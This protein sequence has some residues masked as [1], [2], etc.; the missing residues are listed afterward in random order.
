MLNELEIKDLR[1]AL[2]HCT[3]LIYRYPGIKLENPRFGDFIHRL[4]THVKRNF[5]DLKVYLGIG[6]NQVPYET[7]FD[8]LFFVSFI[9]TSQLG[10]IVT[11][12][13]VRNISNVFYF[14]SY[15]YLRYLINNF[16]EMAYC[17]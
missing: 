5:P 15:I 12:L 13:P 8:Y 11:Y 7:T 4:I 6:G 9:D 2:S 10:T 3:H 1:P 17:R 14:I 16:S